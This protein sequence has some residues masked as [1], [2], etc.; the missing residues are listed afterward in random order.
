MAA[1]RARFGAGLT[2][3]VEGFLRAFASAPDAP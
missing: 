2:E 3:D 1:A